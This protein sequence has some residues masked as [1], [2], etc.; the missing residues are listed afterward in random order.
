ML[1]AGV[2]G[3]SERSEL[4]PCII[5]ALSELLSCND[6]MESTIPDSP[7][8]MIPILITRVMAHQNVYQK[9]VVMAVLAKNE[10]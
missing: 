5:Y 4:T 3:V 6:R 8:R 1:H 7:I 2:K 9:L 10:K